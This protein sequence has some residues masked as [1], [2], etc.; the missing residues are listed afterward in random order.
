MIKVKICGITNL[1]DAQ[2][3]SKSGADAIGFIFS[4]KSPRY[5]KKDVAKKI[6]SE[7]DPFLIKVGVFLDQTK[8]EVLDIAQSLKL[9]I[10][11]FHGSES[12]IFCNSFKDKFK[13]I[14]VFFPQ[15]RPFKNKMDRYKAQAFLFDVRFCDKQKGQ[16]TIPANILKEISGLIKEGKNVIISGGLNSRNVGAIK[17]L[18]PYAVDVASGVESMVGKK[19]EKEIRNFI[20]KVKN[21]KS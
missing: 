11:Q 7:L 14:K 9:D 20:A 21:L 19:S 8:E 6:I 13:I 15:D 4:K 10:L 18:S 1:E 2:M 16:K 12:A 17:K 3:A 5:I